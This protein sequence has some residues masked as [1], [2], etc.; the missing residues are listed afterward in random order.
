[1]LRIATIAIVALTDRA[2]ALAVN[3]LTT[4]VVLTA[5]MAAVLIYL[6]PRMASATLH[7]F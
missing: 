1:M 2:P 5:A 7:F 4:L 3:P 6:I